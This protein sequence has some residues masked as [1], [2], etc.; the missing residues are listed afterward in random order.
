MAE[1]KATNVTWHSGTVTREERHALL[2][3][4]GTVVWMTGLSASGKSTI[5]VILEQ[6]LL[7]SEEARVPARRRQHPDGAEQKS[8]VQ[9]RGPGREHP[10]DRRGRQ[11]V[12]RRR[13]HRHL[14]LHQPVQQGPRRGPGV[15]QARA[16]S[17]RSTW[18]RRWQKP[19]SATRR[20][21][22]RRPGSGQLKGFTGIDDPYE[23]PV[24]PEILVET[25][26]RVCRK[27]RPSRFW[28]TCNPTDT[29]QREHGPTKCAG[30][31]FWPLLVTAGSGGWSVRSIG[32]SRSANTVRQ[33][34]GH[35]VGVVDLTPLGRAVRTRTLRA[36]SGPTGASQ[37]DDSPSRPSC[38]STLI[39]HVHPRVSCMTP[40]RS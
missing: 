18:R 34:R 13:R 8:G 23:A 26:K 14:Q 35:Q 24:Q 9:C 31:C 20:G 21:C 25:E 27:S 40:G 2:S 32:L 22:T 19:R 33:P 15:V 38:R 17:S 39:D 3:Q 11:A 12:R 30:C 37:H 6:M 36:R 28:R 7:H 1:Q 10:P 5:A 16:I 4:K 29:S